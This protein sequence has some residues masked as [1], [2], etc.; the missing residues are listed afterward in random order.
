MLLSGIIFLAFCLCLNVQLDDIQVSFRVASAAGAEEI[1]LYDAGAGEHILFLP[2]YAELEKVTLSSD[3]KK[4]IEIAG[5]SMTAGSSCGEFLL[6]EPYALAINGSAAGTIRFCKSANVAAL[7]IDTATGTMTR[8]HE[9]KNYRETARVRLFTADGDLDHADENATIKGRGNSTWSY[10][11]KPYSLILSA[12]GDLLHMGSAQNWVL[13][14]NAA[15]VTNL[16]NQL[17]FDLARQIGFAWVPDCAYVDVYL[18]G[19]FNG[20][21]QLTEKVEIGPNR[22][23]IDPEAGDFL[24]K[25]DLSGRWDALTD[26]FQTPAG[27]TVE[28]TAPELR[29]KQERNSV[30]AL[31]A[32]ME[33]ELLSG[34]DLSASMLID[35]DSWARRYLIDE[36]AANIDADKVSSYFYRSDGKIY[37][38][39]IWDY[40][41]SFGNTYPNS[42]PQ[43]FLAKMLKKE[44]IA[45]SEYYWSLYQNPSFHTR[46]IEIYRKDV[47]PVLEQLINTEVDV[48]S[49]KIADASRNNYQRWSGAFQ[50]TGEKMTPAQAA[51]QL[52]DYLYARHSFLDSAWLGGVEYCTIQFE[53]IQ[54][55]FFENVSVKKGDVFS[56]DHIDTAETVWLEME[57]GAEYDFSQPVMEDVILVKQS[58]L[59][60]SPEPLVMRDYL[61]I[62]TIAALGALLLC[63]GLMD[64]VR[65]RKERRQQNV[66]SSISS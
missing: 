62:A 21:Y 53:H 9:D 10:Q 35:L 7:Y 42:P 51:E 31:T 6:D 59:N 65:R 57:S 3:F 37:A 25:I 39:P 48:L 13:L 18:N 24:C 14:A 63:F 26:P 45:S 1:M 5:I 15:D 52:K 2:S 41:L 20:L 43:S 19:Q 60:P 8:I 34:K 61:T 66:G 44:T 16:R 32:Q 11:K 40:D 17:V 38:G 47:S 64:C 27:R 29:S 36:I 28:I 54:G 55:K 49:D 56:S 30:I 22:L 58:S 46:M 4:E 50:Q 12:D 23:N 33:Q